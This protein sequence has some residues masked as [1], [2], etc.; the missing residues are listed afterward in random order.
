[1]A[2]FDCMS[3]VGSFTEKVYCKIQKSYITCSISFRGVCEQVICTGTL[4]PT[5]STSDL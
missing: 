5:V 2:V 4:L 1:M 3:L